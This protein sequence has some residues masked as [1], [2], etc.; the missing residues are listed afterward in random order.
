MDQ[1]HEG[2]GRQLQHDTGPGGGQPC[3]RCG[4]RYSIKT[5]YV[6]CFEEGDTLETW[7]DRQH[8]EVLATMPPSVTKNVRERRAATGPTPLF[9]GSSPP[10]SERH[11]EG[12]PDV[13]STDQI[14]G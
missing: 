5:A 6:A 2:H 8:D 7:L 13:L 3:V 14:A 9:N 1:P 11:P 4:L 10:Q 12:G